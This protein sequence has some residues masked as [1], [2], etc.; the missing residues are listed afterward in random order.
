MLFLTP[1]YTTNPMLYTSPHE[2][3]TPLCIANP[4]LCTSPHDRLRTPPL[5]F[6]VPIA[7]NTQADDT[8][9]IWFGAVRELGYLGRIP[10]CL[11][12]PEP[13]PPFIPLGTPPPPALPPDALPKPPPPPDPPKVFAPGW[14][15]E[16]EQAAPLG[17]LIMQKC[18]R[19]HPP[20][21]IYFWA[22]KNEGWQ[23]ENCKF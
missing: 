14:G 8:L 9:S 15:I 21:F 16:F 4:M 20:A 12:V 13:P 23:T 19:N 7:G 3:P 17:L 2:G 18:C 5:R 1:L 10:N 22:S 11:E 6:L